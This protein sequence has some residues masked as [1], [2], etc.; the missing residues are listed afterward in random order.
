MLGLIQT[1]EKNTHTPNENGIL[2]LV[3]GL[4]VVDSYRVRVR[5]RVRARVRA[6]VRVSVRVRIRL[7]G[8]LVPHASG[9]PPPLMT[10]SAVLALSLVTISLLAP[11][12][13][14]I[15]RVRLCW[16]L[17]EWPLIRCWY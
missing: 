13:V 1:L 9:A 15:F 5:V 10:F 17:V 12:L 4:L 7:L 2:T 11:P 14:V 16:S 6:R 3:F 8:L